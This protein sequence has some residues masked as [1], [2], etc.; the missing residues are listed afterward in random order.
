M[1]YQ[2]CCLIGEESLG[3]I[4]VYYERKYNNTLYH[5]IERILESLVAKS[6]VYEF[7]TN[8]DIGISLNAAD[9]VLQMKKKYPYIRLKCAL[10]YEE[11]AEYYPERA[12]DKY[13]DII[14]HCDRELILNR[15]K[16]PDCRSKSI[17]YMIEKSDVVIFVC[18]RRYLQK[19]K[20]CLENVEDRKKYIYLN[21]RTGKTV[22]L[23]I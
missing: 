9:V 5:E 21:P 15:H 7:I 20:Q 14:E 4:M 17:Y 2:K 8:M 6:E 11:Q 19:V 10:P 13:Y 1:V 18:D 3:E 23:K 22:M 16:N 12:R